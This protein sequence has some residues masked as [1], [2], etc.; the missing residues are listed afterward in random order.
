M[1]NSLEAFKFPAGQLKKEQETENKN[2]ERPKEDVN[3]EQRMTRE[4]LGEYSPEEE[5]RIA[6]LISKVVDASEMKPTLNSVA[7]EDL[8]ELRQRNFKKFDSLYKSK[9]E[10]GKVKEALDE[11]K[12]IYTDGRYLP[13]KL[14]LVKEL[15]TE[16]FNQNVSIDE[17]LWKKILKRCKLNFAPNIFGTM[18]MDKERWFYQGMLLAADIKF[19]DENR[20]NKDVHIS[21]EQIKKFKQL[22]TSP[23]YKNKV[24]I[25][26]ALRIFGEEP[27]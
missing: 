25:R 6:S 20:F 19:L 17:K 22:T 8:S 14:S 11:D 24:R 15:F 1:S 23:E 26:R 5:K 10:W 18:I 4:E 16:E 13:E 7:L 21:E 2:T 12:K 27:E 9:F 3:K